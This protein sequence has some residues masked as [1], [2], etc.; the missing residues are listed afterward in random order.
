[1]ESAVRF[2]LR[3]E[4]KTNCLSKQNRNH[5][6]DLQAHEGHFCSLRASSVQVSIHTLNGLLSEVPLAWAFSQE[7][8]SCLSVIFSNQRSSVPNTEKGKRR[9]TLGK[10]CEPKR[11]RSR[12]LPV[13]DTAKKLGIQDVKTKNLQLH[14]YVSLHMDYR[15]THKNIYN[16]HNKMCITGS[17]LCY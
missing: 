10:T 14:V 6:E 4:V 1:M 16:L 11:K 7:M 8:R 2:A 17:Q 5:L 9:D 3:T 13:S 15:H 12:T